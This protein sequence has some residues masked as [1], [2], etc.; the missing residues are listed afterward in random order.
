MGL[1]F[2]TGVESNNSPNWNSSGG[3]VLSILVA[4][5]MDLLGMILDALVYRYLDS[6]GKVTRIDA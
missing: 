5:G 4:G 3:L 2:M 1:N 6:L